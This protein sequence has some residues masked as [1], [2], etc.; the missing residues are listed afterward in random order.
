MNTV[1]R[2]TVVGTL[3]SSALLGLV[4][5][6]RAKAAADQPHMQAA[7]DA[8]RTAERELHEA[9]ADKG[10]HRVRAEKLVHD[11]IAEVEKG[12]NFDRRH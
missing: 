1:S 11:A 4:L 6:S 12:I 8:L 9:E 10:G 7:L 3:F 2:R 5:P